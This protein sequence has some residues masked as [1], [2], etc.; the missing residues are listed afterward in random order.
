[1]LET[2]EVY[3]LRNDLNEKKVQEWNIYLH[4]K[5]VDQDQ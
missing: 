4:I 5:N 2:R 1:M 3:K